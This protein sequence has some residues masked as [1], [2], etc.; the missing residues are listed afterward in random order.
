MRKVALGL[1]LSA[2]IM[3]H[4]AIPMVKWFARQDSY[5][6]FAEA[7]NYVSNT[8]GH[9]LGLQFIVPIMMTLV[10][11]GVG[12]LLSDI[13]W[14]LADFGWIAIQTAPTRLMGRFRK[15]KHPTVSH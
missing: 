6:A 8:M 11:L 13:L 9:L 2:L 5:F 7:V 12:L 3:N 15:E 14:T 4:W 1:I 10:C